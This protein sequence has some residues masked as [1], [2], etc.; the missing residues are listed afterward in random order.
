[1]NNTKEVWYQYIFR[2]FE[3]TLLPWSTPQCVGIDWK[4]RN[5][6]KEHAVRFIIDAE[7]G[8]LIVSGDYGSCIARWDTNLTPA[9]VYTFFNDVGYFVG[10]I[11]CSTDLWDFQDDAVMEDL[12]ELANN[13]MLHPEEKDKLIAH[14]KY[15]FEN[16]EFTMESVYPDYI[17]SELTE[18]CP[19]WRYRIPK[20][21]QR[22]SERINI[23]RRAYRKSYEELSKRKEFVDIL[24]IEKN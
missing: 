3:A 8:N 17:L 19:N 1:M 7:A 23:W 24:G 18:L 12:D 9:K 10:K 11:K 21:G 4:N 22:V 13:S 14:L 5:G 16:H 2:D 6:S 20:L 15:W